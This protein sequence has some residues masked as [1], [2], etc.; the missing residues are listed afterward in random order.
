MWKHDFEGC[1]LSA[2][3]TPATRLCRDNQERMPKV[4]HCGKEVAP[5]PHALSAFGPARCPAVRARQRPQCVTLD[6][7]GAETETAC[8]HQRLTQG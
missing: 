2:T 7:G 5:R 3:V 1:N 8:Q 4:R 6:I